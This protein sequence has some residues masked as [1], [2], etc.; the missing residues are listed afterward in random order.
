MMLWTIGST[1]LYSFYAAFRVDVDYRTYQ[2]Y[3]NVWELG[4]IPNSH[5]FTHEEVIMFDKAYI[6][7]ESMFVI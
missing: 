1:L 2:E 6:Y 3:L 5:Y 7:V 4:G